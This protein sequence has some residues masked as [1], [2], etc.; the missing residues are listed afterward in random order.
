V[1]NGPSKVATLLPPR[2]FATHPSYPHNAGQAMDPFPYTPRPH[3]KN[4]GSALRN[5]SSKMAALRCRRDASH[6]PSCKRKKQK[7]NN[8]HSLA[9]V[10]RGK[11]C[12]INLQRVNLQ[13][14]AHIDLQ[15][16]TKLSS[17]C[18]PWQDLPNQSSEG[19]SAEPSTH[20]PSKD[21]QACSTLEAIECC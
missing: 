7:A 14:Q 10:L 9:A 18:T 20:R 16:I 11:I 6:L 8:Q 12:Q 2:R 5:G 21:H 13:R 17:G 3:K 19:E 15:R 4:E 1:G